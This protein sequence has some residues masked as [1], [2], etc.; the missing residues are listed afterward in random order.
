M[1]SDLK[2]TS[3]QYSISLAVFFV[4]YV[5]F[6]V[7]FNLIL[8]RSRP[9][10]LLPFMMILWGVVTCSMALIRSYRQLVVLRLM[11]GML[12]ASFAPGILHLF[13]SW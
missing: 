8:S 1:A 10:I 12:E 3:I 9:S 2:L 4:S 13:S 11:V 5:V 7:P 6:E